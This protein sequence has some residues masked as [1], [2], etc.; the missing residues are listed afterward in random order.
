MIERTWTRRPTT[1]VPEPGRRYQI[2]P[3]QIAAA[4]RQDPSSPTRDAVA[5]FDLFGVVDV[6]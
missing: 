4:M 1:V 6:P 2:A 3:A 5:P